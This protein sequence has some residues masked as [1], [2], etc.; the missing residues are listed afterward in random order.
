MNRS[1]LLHDQES[2]KPLCQKELLSMQYG[3]FRTDGTVIGRGAFSTV[4]RGADEDGGTA[5]AIKV[6]ER[7]DFMPEELSFFMSEGKRAEEADLNLSQYL[8]S[9]RGYGETLDSVYIASELI[10]GQTLNEWI[11]QQP[12]RRADF[13][14][15]ARLVAQI[16]DGLAFSHQRD[17][18]HRDLKPT[19]I[20]IR[21]TDDSPV[22][23]D[24][25]CGISA[26][27]SAKAFHRKLG[28]GTPLYMDPE[29]LIDPTVI[30][31]ASSD[32]FSLGLILHEMLTG[33]HPFRNRPS[34]TQM[35]ANSSTNDELHRQLLKAYTRDIESPRVTRPEIP[36]RLAAICMRCLRPS[37]RQQYESSADVA[38]DLRRWLTNRRIVWPGAIS[39]VAIATGSWIFWKMQTD[40]PNLQPNANGIQSGRRQVVAD[41]FDDRS[42]SIDWWIFVK[43][44][45]D[46]PGIPLHLSSDVEIDFGK[47]ILVNR[48]YLVSKE[49]FPDGVTVDFK[50]MWTDGRGEYCDDLTVALR[51]SG[52]HL[53]EWPHEVADGITIRFCPD[54]Q[55]LSISEQNPTRVIDR[56]MGLKIE[57]NEWQRIRI[58]DNNETISVFLNNLE[59]P[60]LEVRTKHSA[61]EYRVAFYNREPVGN[62]NKES[63]IDEV[64]LSAPEYIDIPATP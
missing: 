24:F 31:K 42:R 21:S 4:Y 20:M 1:K 13:T 15:I 17:V 46:K 14:V 50:W 12:H 60:V 2:Q 37:H 26:G 55:R 34:L 6:L 38:K 45:I 8:V 25:G 58:T 64:T 44:E 30:P 35:F 28:A 33:F 22:I 43:P 7:E 51:T 36:R 29:R 48:G 5:V 32:I 57:R 41:N 18:F 61:P 16:A 39:I 59:A 49:Q 54:A 63:V 62:I 47:L 19:N 27:E 23:I 52:R 9:V 53:G 3:Q 10:E 56:E 40:R 11:E